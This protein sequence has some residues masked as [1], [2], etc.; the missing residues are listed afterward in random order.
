MLL[1]V[2]DSSRYIDDK[3]GNKYLVFDSTDESYMKIKLN[4]DN[5]LPLKKPL[6]FHVMIIMIISVFEDGKLYQQIF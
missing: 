5:D 6:K 1:Q 3:N 2:N 4:H